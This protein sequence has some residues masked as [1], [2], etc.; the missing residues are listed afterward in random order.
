MS[1]PKPVDLGTIVRTFQAIPELKTAGALAGA[2]ALHHE[3]LENRMGRY[4]FDIDLQNQSEEMESIHRRFSLQTR[5][6]LSLVS[7]LSEEIYEY[8]TRIANR[9]VRI[10]ISRPYLRHRRTY[11]ASKHIAGLFV[12]SLPDL[13]FAKVSAFS[14]RGLPRDLIDLFA[15]DQQKSISWQ[16]LLE[17][18]TRAEDNDYSPTEF[19][20][21]LKQHH[22]ECAESRYREELPVSNSPTAAA[23]K[24]FLKKLLVANQK[25]ALATLE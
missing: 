20:R 22:A 11:Q 18:A 3:H 9:I 13:L 7:K 25:V 5:K 21:K 16:K 10:E 24:Q 2:T 23:L 8:Q 4:S 1:A 15:V 14:T 12:V 17:Q 19:H 6:K